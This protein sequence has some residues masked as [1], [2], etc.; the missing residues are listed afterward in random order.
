MKAVN[1]PITTTAGPILNSPAEA[2]S[3]PLP[4]SGGQDFSALMGQAMAQS[5]PTETAGESAETSVENNSQGN[6]GKQPQTSDPVPLSTV[7]MLA[8]M[9]VPVIQQ[10]TTVTVTAGNSG[11]Q[12]VSGVS[13]APAPET[14]S[15]AADA[16]STNP[17]P[18]TQQL[19]A[20]ANAVES[21][22]VQ[23]QRVQTPV[24]QK[25]SPASEA[26]SQVAPKENSDSK[27]EKSPAAITATTA[28]APTVPTASAPKTDSLS[29]AIESLKPLA[30]VSQPS[31]KSVPTEAAPAPIAVATP[32]PTT[33]M[34]TTTAVKLPD[35]NIV[36]ET[37]VAHPESP[38]V[39]APTPELSAKI[40]TA[41][42]ATAPET[43][44]AQTAEQKLPDAATVTRSS[45]QLGEKA[46]IP[47]ET[48]V[49]DAA[50][51]I[52]QSHGTSSAKYLSPMQKAEKL[53]E[54]AGPTEQ[55]LPVPATSAGSVVPSKTVRQVIS[56]TDSEK[57]EASL[58]VGSSQT[59]SAA[60]REI[61]AATESA[62]ISNPVRTVERAHDLMALHALRLRDSGNDSMQIVIKPSSD[63]HIA[64]NLEM[65]DGTVQV[66]A[67]LQRGD[68]EFLNR[69]WTDLQQQMESRGVKLAP[70]T[71]Q[72]QS[73]SPASNG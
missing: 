6:S 71:N 48:V 18:A 70:L 3:S 10:V 25:P 72:N 4:E 44:P 14:M 56:A 40:S 57:S 17:A 60:T 13:S 67:Q 39:Q 33:T 62:S 19:P 30:E 53:N 22:P 9:M 1:L 38:M 36:L 7:E 59:D 27:P 11:P 23:N 68:Y 61:R 65:R 54:S 8:A 51:E 66:N 29:K 16:A 37:P 49:R 58:P 32:A 69:H 2:A 20:T 73:Q 45:V 43:P 47:A 50:V 41:A 28:S 46:V 21:A 42:E 55:N 64:L 24:M 63:L 34:T 12:E 15:N 35:A 5:T 52:D 26:A 31:Q